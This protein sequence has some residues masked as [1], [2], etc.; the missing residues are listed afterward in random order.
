[1]APSLGKEHPYPRGAN[2]VIRH[3]GARIFHPRASWSETPGHPLEAH[4]AQWDRAQWLESYLD[5]E[6]KE[7]KMRRYIKDTLRKQ[8]V[9][10]CNL[11]ANAV[12]ENTLHGQ[13][14]EIDV[15]RY[16]EQERRKQEH[17]AQQITDAKQD[18]LAQIA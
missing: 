15:G 7:D 1:M 10:R 6:A 16:V 12:K 18:R 3:E 17:E 8:I 2:A 5:E 4:S 9:E 13:A 14:V 11:R